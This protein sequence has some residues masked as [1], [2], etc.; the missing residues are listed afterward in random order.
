MENS[1]P[2]GTPKGDIYSFAIIVNEIVSR[3]GVFYLGDDVTKSPKGKKFISIR[4]RTVNVQMVQ[5][6]IEIF[7]FGTAEDGLGGER[8][9]AAFFLLVKIFETR[10]EFG[11]DFLFGLVFQIQEPLATLLSPRFLLRQTC[12]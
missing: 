8:E 11:V 12:C 7:E 9:A 3:A 6:I 1:K 2:E 5:V 4:V 10:C